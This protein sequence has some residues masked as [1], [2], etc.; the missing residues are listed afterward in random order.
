MAHEIISII[1]L[2]KNAAGYLP[3]MVK[4]ISSQDSPWPVE[5]VVIDSG[6]TDGSVIIIKDLCDKL[7]V[8]LQLATIEPQEFGHGKTRNLAI[9]MASGETLVMLSQD[10]LPLSNDWLTSLVRHL[11]DE[12]VAG[13]FGRQ[14][15]RPGVRLCESLFYEVTYPTEMRRTDGTQTSS[16]SNLSLFFSNVNGAVRKSL[17]IN[18]P[19][20]DD[21][22]MSE[23]QF[24]GRTVLD[25]GY[26]II[27]EP[28][29]AVLHSHNYRLSQLF[30]RYYQSGYSLRQMRM[31]GSVV[32]GGARGNLRLLGQILARN[33]REV[34]YTVLYQAVQG[35]AWLSGRYDLLPPRSGNACYGTEPQQRIWRDFCWSTVWY[36][37]SLQAL[38]IIRVVSVNEVTPGEVR[39]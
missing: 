25:E 4:A 19:F 27:Y 24:W 39:L 12:K 37:I 35:I 9:N 18:Y 8:R 32:R 17:A 38:G 20:R 28:A 21:L 13:V 23:D 2:V 10:A 16:F 7:G 14:I 22:V 34:R 11:E 1:I 15:A 31:R 26:S 33:P 5:V 30:K 3:D 29:A 6:S 36:G